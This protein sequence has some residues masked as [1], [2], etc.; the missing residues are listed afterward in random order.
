[1]NT[2]LHPSFSCG[3]AGLFENDGD[4][5]HPER[6]EP[7]YEILYVT[8]GEVYLTEGDR[9][10]HLTEGQL[11][12][13]APGVRHAGSRVT[14]GVGFYWLHFSVEQ[15]ALPFEARLFDHFEQVSLFREYLHVRHLPGCPEYLLNSI[16]LHILSELCHRSGEWEPKPNT[17]AEKIY[18]WLRINADAALTVQK[19][20]NRFGYSSDHLS[21]ICKQSF[22]LGACA[23]INRFVCE[24]AKTLLCNTERYVK[25]IAAE[26]HFT[27]DKA[28]IAFFKYHEG[29][30]PSEFRNRFSKLHMNKA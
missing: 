4:W 30:F 13:L 3:Y 21:R 19:A 17:T 9:E 1:M 18:E 27:D 8:K 12:L 28:F 6:V 7:T 14:S 23:L 26:L 10:Y 11:L 22:G 20:A 2:L 15:G 25:E 16:L 5:I 29:C 24:R